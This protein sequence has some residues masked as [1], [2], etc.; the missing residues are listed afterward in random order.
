MDKIDLNNMNIHH[1]LLKSYM[2][3]FLAVI[4]GVAIDLFFKIKIFLNMLLTFLFSVLKINQLVKS[5]S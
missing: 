4:L 2:T 3:F 1:V 5:I